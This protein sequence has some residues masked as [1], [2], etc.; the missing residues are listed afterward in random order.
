MRVISFI[1]LL[2]TLF[3][4]TQAS[5]APDTAP[6][7][8]V[9]WCN[10]EFGSPTRTTGECICKFEC[11]GKGCKRDQG[12]I[13]YAYESCPSCQCVARAQTDGNRNTE[14]VLPTQPKAPSPKA[15]PSPKAQFTKTE[16]QQPHI[17]EEPFVLSEW[18]E[19]NG[20]NI[21]ALVVTL[22]FLL[23]L[24]PLLYLMVSTKIGASGSG[25][26]PPP[27]G[28]SGSSGGSGS[29]GSSGGNKESSKDK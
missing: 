16:E 7:Y 1:F 18:L 9:G 21:F 13:W 6:D 26:I 23:F 20:T 8:P 22:F 2:V 29:S 24:L 10:L 3:S 15:P 11:E 14:E 5:R 27:S 19:D 25:R 28:S 4:F 12:Y 17:D